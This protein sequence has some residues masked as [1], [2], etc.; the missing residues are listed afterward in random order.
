MYN[1]YQKYRRQAILFGRI[2]IVFAIFWVIFRRI[3]SSDKA[4]SYAFDQLSIKDPEYLLNGFLLMLGF[5]LLNWFFEVLKWQNLVAGIRKISLSDSL[6][7]STVALSLALLTPNRIGEYGAKPVFF[8][9]SEQ[10]KVV[11]LNFLGNTAQMLVT[12]LFGFFGM[13][14]LWRQLATHFTMTSV[15]LI[16]VIALLLGVVVMRIKWIRR[17]ISKLIR[18]LKSIP[19]NIQLKNGIYSV[20]R[21]L[22]FSHQFYFLLVFFGVPVDYFTAMYLIFTTYLLASL[23]PGFV[24]FDFLIKGSV[25]AGLFALFGVNEWLILGITGLMWLFNFAL[26]ALL[27]SFYLLRMK[28]PGTEPI[29]VV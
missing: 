3:N 15:W 24:A 10:K 19:V 7:Q 23:I 18:Y 13:F 4:Y 20:V 26:P 5:T 2:L 9:R 14:F 29:K 8:P 27:G 1:F 16:L 28:I 21:Y 6:K 11:A 25:A 22:I 12:V 17:W